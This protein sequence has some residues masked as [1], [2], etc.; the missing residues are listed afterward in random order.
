MLLKVY[1]YGAGYWLLIMFTIIIFCNIFWLIEKNL[2]PALRYDYL[3]IEI[4]SLLHKRADCEPKAV[5]ETE[6]VDRSR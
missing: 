6:V 4:T 5:G 1:S 3:R 2:S